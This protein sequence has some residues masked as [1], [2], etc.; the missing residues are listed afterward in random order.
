MPTITTQCSRGC[1]GTG[2]YSGFA[3][4][5]PD[6]VAVVCSGCQGT[7]AEKFTYTEFTGRKGRRGIKTV[8]RSAGSLLVTGVGPV[9][10]S[11]TYAEFKKG[12]MP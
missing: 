4:R 9:G 3:I 1:D 2:L 7:G 11:V 8:R 12:K 5:E 6:W 10:G